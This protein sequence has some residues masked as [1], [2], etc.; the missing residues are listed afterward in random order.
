VKFA[1]ILASAKEAA[2]LNAGGEDGGKFVEALVLGE[3]AGR[4]DRR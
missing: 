1:K 3:V 4:W 2:A